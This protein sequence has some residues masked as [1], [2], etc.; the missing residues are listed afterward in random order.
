[1]A[2]F[3]GGGYL[4]PFYFSLSTGDGA[5][6]Q[7]IPCWGNQP[8]QLQSHTWHIIRLP[9]HVKSEVCRVHPFVLRR[10]S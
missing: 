6:R 2:F 3:L 10:L 4:N 7:I 9:A 1:M 5:L 8:L